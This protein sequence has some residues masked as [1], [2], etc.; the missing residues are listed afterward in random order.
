MSTQITHSR[1]KENR[2]SR[3]MLKNL[4]LLSLVPITIVL[5]SVVDKKR[6]YL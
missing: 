2:N 5:A 1:I 4:L 6:I 3:E